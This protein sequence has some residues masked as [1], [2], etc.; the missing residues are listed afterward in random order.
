MCALQKALWCE[1]SRRLA[2]AADFPC[3]QGT[4]LEFGLA[5]VDMLYGEEKARLALIFSSSVFAL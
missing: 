4:A 5:L 1:R 3:P 2:A